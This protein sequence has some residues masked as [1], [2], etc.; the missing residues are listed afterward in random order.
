[1]KGKYNLSEKSHNIMTGPEECR[2]GRDCKSL[3]TY[4]VLFVFA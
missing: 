1:M 2:R 4:G 3:C